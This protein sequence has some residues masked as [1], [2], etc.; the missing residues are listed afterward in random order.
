MRY[1]SCEQRFGASLA[2]VAQFFRKIS[3]E[4][5]ADADAILQYS[6]HAAMRSL[7]MPTNMQCLLRVKTYEALGYGDASVTLACPGPSLAGIMVDELGDSD[8]KTFFYQH[9]RDAPARTFLAVTEPGAGSILTTMKTKFLYDSSGKG[10]LN[11][12]KWL[13]S[14]GA[15]AQL[16]VVIVKTG[17]K[18]LGVRALLLS[19]AVLAQT[20]TI[21]R[22]RL[23]M[24]GL[25]G[26]ALARLQFHDAD[27][28]SSC[29]LGNHK[30]ALQHGMMALIKTFN[31]MRPCVA[32]LAIGIAQAA[33][34]YVFDSGCRL[35]VAELRQMRRLQQRVDIVREMLYG[36]A[37]GV[38]RDPFES[39]TVSLAKAAATALA[40]KIVTSVCAL[41]GVA[42]VW[43]PL[44]EKWR[45]DV[46]GFEYMEGTRNIQKLN[47]FQ[48]SRGMM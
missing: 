19:P 1:L 9:F 36:A 32:A 47:V 38:D 39:G 8:Q 26:A 13:I 30:S 5:D 34:D 29:L 43:H 14:H 17:H 45:R 3:L 41:A 2:M 28:A 4:I 22:T 27:V 37:V 40:E 20:A 16:G 11:G 23:S 7:V 12:E 18:A 48:Q 24:T 35:S 21:L 33:I 6:H 46:A 25:R 44:L 42:S 10:K 15:T 31:R